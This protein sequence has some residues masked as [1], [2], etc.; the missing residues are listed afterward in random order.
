MAGETSYEIAIR[1]GG[2]GIYTDRN[3]HLTSYT[4]ERARLIDDY[5]N[6]VNMN[7]FSGYGWEN[8][9]Y[10]NTVYINNVLCLVENIEN[11]D[12]VYI[13]ICRQPEIY[14]IEDVSME[15]YNSEDDD[16][17][18]EMDADSGTRVVQKQHMTINQTY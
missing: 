13:S 1:A 14:N 18:Y 9:D 12:E 2:I 15:V 7:D 6:V 8:N 5:G 10:P 11:S 16:M 17:L 3:L 4:T